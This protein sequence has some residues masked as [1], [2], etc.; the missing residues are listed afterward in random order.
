MH[1]FEC[2]PD[3]D[4]LQGHGLM[5]R[6]HARPADGCIAGWGIGKLACCILGTPV[7]SPLT[8]LLAILIG[9]TKQ[10]GWCSYMPA[11]AP[12]RSWDGPACIAMAVETFGNYGKGARDT[13]SRLTSH[14]AIIISLSLPKPS[15]SV[16]TCRPIYS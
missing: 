2:G 1:P 16:M 13:F 9:R 6:S 3:I 7:A 8:L 10:I 15:I 11:L 4:K 14:L 5:H 12:C